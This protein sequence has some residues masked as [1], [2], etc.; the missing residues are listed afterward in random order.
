LG[1]NQTERNA[2]WLNPCRTHLGKDFDQIP[3]ER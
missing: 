2:R 3:L 1:L